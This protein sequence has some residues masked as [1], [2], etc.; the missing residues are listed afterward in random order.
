MQTYKLRAKQKCEST[1]N[2]KKCYPE[3]VHIHTHTHKRP[4]NHIILLCHEM[5]I[6]ALWNL[7]VPLFFRWLCVSAWIFICIFVS[8]LLTNYCYH[9]AFNWFT[10]DFYSKNRHIFFILHAFML[11]AELLRSC[12]MHIS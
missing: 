12:S 3:S 10:N 4:S 7:V 6:S 8:L 1:N 2:G 11:F 9:V 5:E